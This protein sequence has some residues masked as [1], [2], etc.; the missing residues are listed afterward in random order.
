[1]AETLLDPACG[2]AGF[3]GRGVCHLE[4]QCKTVQERRTLQERSI[5]G[6]RRS[7]LP[8]MLAQMNLLLHG[9]DSPAVEYGNKP[10]CEADRTRRPRSCG[11]DPDQSTIGGE[12]EAG[13]RANFPA[14]KQTSENNFAFPANSSCG[15]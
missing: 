1:L 15:S 14:D 6:A 7:P 5:Q 11:R 13:I 4:T 12:E 10:G 3:S 9:L 8:Y 2:T